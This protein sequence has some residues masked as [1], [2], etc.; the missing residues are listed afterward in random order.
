MLM[1]SDISAQFQQDAML[2][3]DMFL[4][5]YIARL[6]D[7]VTSTNYYPNLKEHPD[8]HYLVLTKPHIRLGPDH[9]PDPKTFASSYS[10]FCTSSTAASVLQQT[11]VRHRTTQQII[12][13]QITKQPHPA[14]PRYQTTIR[15]Q[16]PIR[17]QTSVRQQ[18]PIITQLVQRPRHP[19]PNVVVAPSTSGGAAHLHQVQ[20]LP[21]SSQ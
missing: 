15:Q 13:Q 16:A 5:N 17:Q 1:A 3:S 12:G 4:N 14:A 10:S 6:K 11:P 2:N 8:I 9:P 19:A 20:T 7:S 18:A 21:T